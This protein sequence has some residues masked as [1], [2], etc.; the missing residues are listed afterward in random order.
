MSWFIKA[1]FHG[2]CLRL[3][4][5]AFS[6]FFGMILT[7]TL[8]VEDYGRYGFYISI[9]SI[10]TVIVQFGIP[11]LLINHISGR[12]N[13]ELRFDIINWS[14]KVIY[15]NALALFVGLCLVSFFGYFDFK[16][17]FVI[18]FSILL[19]VFSNVYSS[20]IKSRE[21]VTLGQIN[22]ALIKPVSFF[23]LLCIGFYILKDNSLEVV[24]SF[25][26]VSVLIGFLILK[27]ITK[28]KLLPVF[29]TGT[30]NLYFINSFKFLSYD[31]IKIVAGQAII[32]IIPY[33]TSMSDV[34]LYKISFSLFMLSI[35]P[36]TLLASILAPKYSQFNEMH[37]KERIELARMNLLSSIVMVAVP[38]AIFVVFY[39]YGIN[40][41][42]LL[43]SDEFVGANSILLVLLFSEIVCGLFGN[44]LLLLSMAG[45]QNEVLVI[46]LMSLIILIVSAV[47]LIPC[48]GAIGAAYS[49]LLSSVALRFFGLLIN[50]KVFKFDTSMLFSLKYINDFK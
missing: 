16:Y 10:C 47:F 44:P 7:R 13:S 46:S 29:K 50:I 6:L 22:E 30:E 5:M 31:F 48:Y 49:V 17:M 19:S 42:K 35:V 2:G 34:G 38:I 3:L 33:Y 9:I 45:R 15:L 8:G 24:M 40:V 27:K 26:L 20:E 43:F 41:I 18:Y 37:I 12:V 25:N 36:S 14:L 21:K 4:G 23:I 32:L 1:L 11:S 39:V 28:I